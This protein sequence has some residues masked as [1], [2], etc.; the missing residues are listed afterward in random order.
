MRFT[1]SVKAIVLAGGAGLALTGLAGASAV[2][3]EVKGFGG[4]P[5]LWVDGQ[6]TT[7]L[8]HWHKNIQTNDVAVFRDAGVHLYSFEGMC[9]MP[10]PN[11][12]PVDY[13]EGRSYALPVLT[14]KWVDEKM[15]LIERTD[16]QAKVLVRLWL[17]TPKW[18]AEA[19]PEEC[20]S[21]YC[22]GRLMQ[23]NW[24][25]PFSRRWR[26]DCERAMRR[27]M[28]YIEGKW[29]HLVLG[30]HPGMAHCAEN[31]YAWNAGVADLSPAALKA[32]PVKDVDPAV[33]FARDGNDR[34]RLL[35]EAGEEKSVELMRWESEQM[36]DAVCF[37]SHVVK[38]ELKRLGRTKV[39]G[40]F[41]GYVAMPMA[42]TSQMGC[43]HHCHERVLACPDVD[44]IA[45][46]IDYTSRQLG[47]TSYAQCLPGSVALHGKLYYA[48]EDTRYHLASDR[49][50]EKVSCDP[51]DTAAILRRTFF[52]AYSHGGTIWWMDLPGAG[53][54]RDAGF[55]PVLSECRAFADRHAAARRSVAQIAVFVDEKSMCADRVAPVPLSTEI[56]Q[57]T[58]P[59][60]ASCGAPYDVFRLA[61][62]SALDASG[63]L[64]AC[65]LAV[66][67]TSHAALPED[68]TALREKLCR[69]NRIVVFVG[70]AGWVGG[71]AASF[72][73][74]T[75]VSVRE[76]KS[77]NSGFVEWFADGRRNVFGSPVSAHP[78]LVV[79]D[80][81]AEPVGWYVQASDRSAGGGVAVARR[82]L[83][84]WTSVVSVV[85]MVPSDLIRRLAEEA[86]AHVYSSAGDQVFAGEGWCAVAAKAPGVRQVKVPWQASPLAADMKRGDIRVF[87]E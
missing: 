1:L 23:R 71:G 61:D 24:A 67:L 35:D 7:G 16:P 70:P 5:A 39:C 37:L 81:A 87:E 78:S 33:F 60:I 66:V 48:E 11:G 84:G 9:E 86:G 28:R 38:D 43:G 36:A 17:G 44:F 85:N 54:Y 56:L 42:T 3:S 72:A 8:M 10:N 26:E 80:A 69:G 4:V 51:K 62:V 74:L 45:A 58:L 12:E 29:G 30:Y 14:E 63:R 50:C 2:V 13:R 75:G 49:D 20:V 21:A 52:D 31:A 79:D 6:P 59:E 32:S 68:K 18:W 27:T 15:G 65:R 53:W 55:V 82:K 47:G 83:D 76:L 64:N 57:S 22:H 77:R 41:Y 73:A 46:P 19:H 40:A 25:S 34:R